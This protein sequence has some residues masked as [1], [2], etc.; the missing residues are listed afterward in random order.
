MEIKLDGTHFLYY[1][2]MCLYKLQEKYKI[3]NEPFRNRD[4]AEDACKTCIDILTKEFIGISS[5]IASM[6]AVLFFLQVKLGIPV[7]TLRWA[8]HATTTS[9]SI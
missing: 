6:D 2:N 3:S 4:I 8:T 9:K 5:S 1:K 7:I